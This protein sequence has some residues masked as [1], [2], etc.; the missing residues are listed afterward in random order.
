MNLS[1]AIVGSGFAKADAEVLLASLL[2]KDRTWLLAHGDEELSGEMAARWEE[3]VRRRSGGEPVAYITGSKEFYG[4]PF[5]VTR[6]TLIPRPA[7]EALVQTALSLLRGEEPA[8][9]I[10]E[11]DTGIVAWTEMLGSMEGVRTIVDVGTGS[12]CIGITLA[13]ERPDLRVI[14]T[15]IDPG[16]LLVAKENTAVLGARTVECRLGDGLSPVQDLTEPFLLVSNPPYIPEGTTLERDVAEFEPRHALFSGIA[17]DDMLRR[18]IASART[19]PYC[20]GWVMECRTE[21]A[22]AHLDS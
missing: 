9:A 18:L 7:T 6:A 2:G 21:Q 1:Q 15:D 13:L 4:R 17:G 16:T 8:H 10:T 20:R 14:A 19:H 11:I 3:W 12:G 5:R 22:R